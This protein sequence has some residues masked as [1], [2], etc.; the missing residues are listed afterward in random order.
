M[1]YAGLFYTPESVCGDEECTQELCE[2]I[3][4]HKAEIITA[5]LPY[6][7]RI[8]NSDEP[9]VLA[10]ELEQMTPDFVRALAQALAADPLARAVASLQMVLDP[11]K[12]ADDD[13]EFDAAFE[14]D[15]DEEDE[16]RKE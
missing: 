15:D 14:E 6:W 8:T 4:K 2:E 3:G 1:N 13:G 12:P 16:K 7:K 10:I 11:K 5:M 9:Y